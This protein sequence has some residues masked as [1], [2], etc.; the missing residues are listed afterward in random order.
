MVAHQPLALTT[1][2]KL[3]DFKIRANPS[4]DPRN[5]VKTAIDDICCFGINL[6]IIILGRALTRAARLAY[7]RGPRPSSGYSMDSPGPARGTPPPR[8]RVGLAGGTASP[9]LREART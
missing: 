6:G 4:A 5:G 2:G 8:S 7:A 9:A 3:A 1:L